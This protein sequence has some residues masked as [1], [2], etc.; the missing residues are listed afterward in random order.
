MTDLADSLPGV[1]NVHVAAD[2]SG[3]DVTFLRTVE[4]GPT[5]RSYGVHVADLAGVPEPVV[6]RSEDVLRRL[7]E[8]E[9]IDVR[10]GG[11]DGGTQQVVFDLESGQ[12]DRRDDEEAADATDDS[13]A[14]SDSGSTDD[15]NGAALT[16]EQEA[17]LSDVLDTSVNELTPV[18]ALSMI[19]EWQSELADAE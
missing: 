3:D 14:T 19:Q 7:R 1:R 15:A 12:F 6:E 8:D 13:G 11:S 16:P 17:V 10:G 2:D 4:E 18:E 5:N 9:A